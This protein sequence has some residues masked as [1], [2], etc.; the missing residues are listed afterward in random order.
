MRSV[1]YAEL[2]SLSREDVLTAMKDY[3]EAEVGV[4]HQIRFWSAIPSKRITRSPFLPTQEILLNLGRKRL[5]EARKAAS[6]H[7][8]QLTRKGLLAMER[9]AAELAAAGGEATRDQASMSGVGSSVLS[10]STGQIQQPQQQSTA[11]R[12]SDRIRSDVFGL[13]RAIRKS[14]KESKR[15][16]SLPL[17][18]GSFRTFYWA[19]GPT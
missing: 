1:G 13:K 10:G 17:D 4:V 5:L 7:R 6:Q 15:F 16:V 3:P 2:F 19:K 12:L 18:V 11:S 14:F 9:K 8:A